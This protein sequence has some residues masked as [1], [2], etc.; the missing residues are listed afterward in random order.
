M[1][2]WLLVED[3]APITELIL[4]MFEIWGIESLSF[5]NGEQAMA[6]IDDVQSGRY[7]GELPEL[8]LLDILLPG[9]YTGSDVA[10]KMSNTP[11]LR[12]VAK[13]MTTTIKLTPEEKEK[14][15]RKTKYDKWLPK[16]IPVGDELRTILD[17]VIRK[18]HPPQQGDV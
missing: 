15:I 5:V 3:E 16:P 13:V 6:W 4:A 8:A 14:V 11:Q 2:T 9:E 10:H 17:D 12:H 18:K 1:T 7:S